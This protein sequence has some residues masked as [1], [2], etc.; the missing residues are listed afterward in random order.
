MKKL[1]LTS[2]IFFTQ[3][4]FAQN[5]NVYLALE[6]TGLHQQ[7][8]TFNEKLDA[9]GIFSRYDIEPFLNKHPLHVTLYLTNYTED[10]LPIIEQKIANIAKHWHPIDIHTTNLF[11]T[12]GNYLML[13]V[14]NER[15]LNGPNTAL[16][17]LSDEITLALAN[18]RDFTAP[19]PPWAQSI[20]EKRKAFL[21]YGSPNVFFEYSPHLSLMAKNF[22]D[23]NQAQQ[24]QAELN[25]L[26]NETPFPALNIKAYTIGI[27]EV[28]EFGQIT[29]ALSR[30]SLS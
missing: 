27:G 20:P 24:F 25:T 28:D 4:L 11:L 30:Y 29:R 1:I 18:D 8:Q 15:P 14:D 12:A 23:P 10:K 17:Q 26:I 13:D 6:D 22:T 2:L 9:L 16:Q 7:I 21:G 19:I 5:I 3:L